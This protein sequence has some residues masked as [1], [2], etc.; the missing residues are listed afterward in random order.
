M[1]EKPFTVTK[2]N[3]IDIKIFAYRLNNYGC[4]TSTEISKSRF[5]DDQSCLIGKDWSLIFEETSVDY[6]DKL[7]NLVLEFHTLSCL[8][9]DEFCELTPKHPYTIVWLPDGG[10]LINHNSDFVLNCITVTGWRLMT[11]SIVLEKN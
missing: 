5:K 6:E 1:K 2:L 9:S 4:I 8:H 7:V 3:T 10:F 11:S